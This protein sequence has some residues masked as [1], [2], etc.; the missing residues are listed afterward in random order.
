MSTREPAL[1]RLRRG[2]PVFGAIQLFPLP[3]SAEMALWCG[4]DFVVI[5]CEHGIVDEGA[6]VASL[7]LLSPTPAFSAVRVR[8]GDY[9]GV[10]KYLDFG[11]DGIL[12]P[13]VRSGEEAAAFVSAAR[14]G[15]DGTRS[16]SAAV[17]SARFGLGPLADRTDPLL[18]ALI[19]GR[20]GV[21]RI[22][23]IV[24][25]EG[26]SGIVIGPNDLSADLGKPGDYDCAD[27]RRAFVAVETAALAAGLIIGTRPHPGFPASLLVER[28]HR[29]LLAS[30]DAIALR[31]GLAA[32]LLE[33][34]NGPRP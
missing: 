12:M 30:A 5:D 6:Q 25:V 22:D 16:S 11:A 32:D 1:E 26:L 14:F 10:G 33:A 29:F 9:A 3:S 8:A 27:Y 19:E 24:R 34:K 21:Q 20:A 31:N 2:H 7:Q 23:E 13:E 4:Y 17:R 18:L 28:G 15:P